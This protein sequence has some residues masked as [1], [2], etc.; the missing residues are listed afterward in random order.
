MLIRS[1]ITAPKRQVL[2]VGRFAGECPETPRSLL[3]QSR[4]ETPHKKKKP[5]DEP[6]FVFVAVQ[7]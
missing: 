4:P 5:G 1:A 7:R 6:G 2:K 3:W